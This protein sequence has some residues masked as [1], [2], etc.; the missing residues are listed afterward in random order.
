MIFLKNKFSPDQ[1]QP[2]QSQNTV[3]T[4]VSSIPATRDGTKIK[5]GIITYVM[6]CGTTLNGK[7]IADRLG[8]K[9]PVMANGTEKAIS[10]HTS[11]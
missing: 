4:A 9:I 8:I 5:P 6:C 10:L 11:N 2:Y 7:R 3:F 1:R